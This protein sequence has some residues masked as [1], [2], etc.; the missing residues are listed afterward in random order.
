MCVTGSRLR[1]KRRCQDGYCIV[2][3]RLKGTLHQQRCTW[4]L[5][6]AEFETY[7]LSQ[8]CL[9]KVST[10]STAQPCSLPICLFIWM[11]KCDAV[12]IVAVRER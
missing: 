11:N 12:R 8:A 2:I 7:S 3:R 6:D 4:R 9:S 5:W 1:R 10:A